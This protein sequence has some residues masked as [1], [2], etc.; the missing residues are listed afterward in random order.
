MNGDLSKLSELELMSFFNKRDKATFGFIYDKIY[1]EVFYFTYSYFSDTTTDPKDVVQDV[2]VEIWEKHKT[3]FSTLRELK[4]YIY[5][6]IRNKKH[7]L[8]SH[9][10]VIGKVHDALRLED[11][12]FV[13]QAVEAEVYSYLSDAIDKLPAECAKTM[14]LFLDGYEIKEIA[15]MLNKKES[16]IYNQKKRALELLKSAIRSN[17]IYISALCMLLLDKMSQ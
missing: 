13:T 15:A 14:K 9:L 7:S 11:E 6:M 17:D 5:V 16:T 1:K 8:F 2:F 12:R 10:N 3:K 4:G